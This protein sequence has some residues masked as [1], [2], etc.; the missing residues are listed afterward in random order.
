MKSRVP[1]QADLAHRQLHRED[2]AVLPLPGYH[3]ADPDDPPF[4]GREIAPEIGIVLLP[5]GCGHQQAHVPTHGL[6]R[7]PAEQPLSRG[8]EGVDQPALVDHHQRVRH[9]LKDRAEQRPTPIDLP[10][11]PLGLAQ[12]ARD[13]AHP[14]DPSPRVA[15]RADGE[16]DGDDPPVLVLPPGLEPGELLPAAHPLEDRCFLRDPVGRDDQGD[17]PAHDLVGGIA[18]QRFGARVPEGDGP[19]QV[20]ADDRVVHRIRDGLEPRPPR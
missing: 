8:T 10:A 17:L 5:V 13:L 1:G 7:R 3:A 18:E 12:V 19:V 11:R 14:D 20:L 15:E 16:R 6:D 9:G 2:A 4:P